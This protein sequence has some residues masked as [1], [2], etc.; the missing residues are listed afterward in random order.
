MIK[1]VCI[2][3]TSPLMSL[4][5]FRLKN[6]FDINIYEKNKNIGGAWQ[7]N[8][9]NSSSYSKF[10]NIIIPDNQ[11]EDE[12][13]LEINE[14]LKSWG[15]N[16]EKPELPVIPKYP[17]EAKNIYTHDF[18]NFYQNLASFNKV[19]NTEIRELNI[20][21]DS[22]V[23]NSKH[24][25]FLFLPS[26]FLIENLSIN[27]VKF[28]I[29]PKTVRSSHISTIFDGGDLSLCTYDD[30]FDNIFDRGQIRV[31]DD[32]YIF[33]GRVKKQFKNKQLNYLCN[34]SN[35]LKS[36]KS[37]IVH[38]EINFFEH[39]ILDNEKLLDF[40][41]R[42]SNFPISIV[43]TRQLNNGYLFLNEPIEKLEKMNKNHDL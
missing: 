7:Y 5:F 10:T 14:E 26:N 3:G 11:A 18:S 6:N 17:Y 21:E 23:V 43:E 39:H 20:L 36:I 30:D 33:T 27:N 19:T 22:V 38:K 25:D 31:K 12:I 28:D 8:S 32:R 16:I 37:K 13:I 9:Y 29:N 34:E 4:I 40:K 1:K 42:V 15:C 2:L 35:Y 24:F 41:I